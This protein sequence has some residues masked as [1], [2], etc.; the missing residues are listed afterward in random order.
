MAQICKNC[1]KG[2][3]IRT[4]KG[5]KRC[6]FCGYTKYDSPNRRGRGAILFPKEEKEEKKKEEIPKVNSKKRHVLPKGKGYHTQDYQDLKFLHDERTRL[7]RKRDSIN[8]ILKELRKN[9][10]SGIKEVMIEGEL[11]DV[12]T[13]KLVREKEKPTKKE[14][15]EFAPDRIIEEMVETESG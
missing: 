13:G 8:K 14:E 7:S 9:K 12:E 2:F 3:L 5:R 1:G 6:K 4:G 15:E 11:W 10:Y